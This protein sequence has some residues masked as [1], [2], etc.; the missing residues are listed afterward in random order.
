MTTTDTSHI[1]HWHNN[2]GDKRTVEFAVTGTDSLTVDIT[3]ANE[4]CGMM[5]MPVPNSS[6]LLRE[7]RAISW[8]IESARKIWDSLISVGW[9]VAT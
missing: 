2:T 4:G 5:Y 7:G 8:S 6:W 9:K 3:Y 1:L